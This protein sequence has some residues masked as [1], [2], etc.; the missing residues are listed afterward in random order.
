MRNCQ[1]DPR[2]SVEP[3]CPNNSSQFLCRNG[4][5]IPNE[6]KCDGENDCLDGSDEVCFYYIFISYFYFLVETFMSFFK[7][8]IYTCFFIEIYCVLLVSIF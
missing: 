1:R 5:C 7:N 3:L 8:Y 2:E 6:W 4:R